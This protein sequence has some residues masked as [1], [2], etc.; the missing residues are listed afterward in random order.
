MCIK[1]YF[2]TPAQAALFPEST[3]FPKQEPPLGRLPHQRVLEAADLL[4]RSQEVAGRNS[5]DD[6]ELFRALGNL[7]RQVSPIDEKGTAGHKRSFVR[8]EKEDR[9]GNF[10]GSAGA[11]NG[12]IRASCSPEL[13]HPLRCAA[14][15]EDIG[16]NGGRT[17]AIDTNTLGGISRGQRL[18][19][20]ESSGLGDT[21]LPAPV[22]TATLS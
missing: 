16:L 11:S 21:V 19:E 10:I 5:A 15:F 12:Q 20:P 13:S 9:I 2:G 1:F 22:A 3:S 8:S 17:N 18:G 6:A 4:D 7:P 14:V